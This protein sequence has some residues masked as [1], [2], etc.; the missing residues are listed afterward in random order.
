MTAA[1][2]ATVFERGRFCARKHVRVIVRDRQ[3]VSDLEPERV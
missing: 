1:T 3:V 2:I